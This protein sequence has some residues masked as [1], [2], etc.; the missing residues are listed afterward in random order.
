MKGVLIGFDNRQSLELGLALLET[1]HIEATDVYSPMPIEGQVSSS[2]LPLLMF[3]AG[4]LGFV[5]FFLLMSYADLKAYPLNIG[6]RPGFA[7]PAF[8][9][10]A[11]ELGVLCA[12]AAGFFGYFVRCRL[13]RLYDGVDEC[14]SFG[15]ASRDGWFL[16]I[17][18]ED[19]QRLAQARTIVQTL[20]PSSI[21]E[22]V[23]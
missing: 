13:P 14:P 16:E 5:G 2:G 21:E 22:F 1:A 8:V 15:N 19:G 7:W 9:P 4:M 12:M 6:G 23:A 20:M 10:I 17:R 18:S 11:F 3:A